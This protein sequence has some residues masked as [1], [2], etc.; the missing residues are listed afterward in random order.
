MQTT[1][2]PNY[3][4]RRTRKINNHQTC[5]RHWSSS[6]NVT[7]ILTRSQPTTIQ[8]VRQNKELFASGRPALQGS[9]SLTLWLDPRENN[10]QK[11]LTR[12]LAPAVVRQRR[13]EA[14][15]NEKA[16]A[17]LGEHRKRREYGWGLRNQ[18][19]FR[20][21]PSDMMRFGIGKH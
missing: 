11:D 10:N 21:A 16:S 3:Q 2:K 13:L 14:V 12:I 15:I 1:H 17:S 19:L 20:P 4:R 7:G 5:Q 8:H 6:S 18:R 9:I